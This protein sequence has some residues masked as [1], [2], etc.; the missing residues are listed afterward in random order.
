MTKA[1][2]VETTEIRRYSFDPKTGS[3]TR[4]HRA[5][6]VYVSYHW[7]IRKGPG[8]GQMRVRRSWR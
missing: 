4:T 1:F 8:K 7:R 3:C 5:I 2:K 6:D